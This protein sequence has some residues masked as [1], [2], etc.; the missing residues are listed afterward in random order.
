MADDAAVPQGAEESAS[1][2]ALDDLF[3]RTYEELRRLA[4][5]VRRHDRLATVGPTALVNEAWIK[6]AHAPPG[7]L[8]SHLHFKRV[9][10]RA[11]RQVL[12]ES[13][14]RRHAGK[15]GAGAVMV[16]LGDGVDRADASAA[17]V[18]AID[19]ALSDLAR[20]SARQAAIVE[21]R[22]FGGFAIAEIAELLG[23]SEATVERDW[24][25][26]RAWLA[27]SLARG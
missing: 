18:L 20:L 7:V 1:R 24:R 5:S 13:A 2:A 16:T 26:A 14:R 3:S 6:M 10:A 11:M 12:V 4:S 22:F 8:H 25:A 21:H 19:A 17:D 23:L 27:R 9:A 15:R